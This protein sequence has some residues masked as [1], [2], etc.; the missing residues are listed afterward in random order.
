MLGVLTLTDL[1]PRVEAD[2]FFSRD[3]PQLRASR[4]LADRFPSSEQV[5]IRSAA[6]D[7]R[8]DTYVESVSRLADDLDEIEG[9]RSVNSIASED[10]SG[11]PLWRRHLW[12]SVYRDGRRLV[13]TDECRR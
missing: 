2:F 8:S 10:A 13:T 3:D 11:S 12:I 5:I 1:S 7:V 9:V 6:P 4:E